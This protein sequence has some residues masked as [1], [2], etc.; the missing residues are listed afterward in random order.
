[1]EKEHSMNDFVQKCGGRTHGESLKMP[2]VFI[3]SEYMGDF[4]QLQKQFLMPPRAETLEQIKCGFLDDQP[5]KVEGAFSH[6]VF[7]R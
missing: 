5:L 4:P 3:E 2:G 7:G 1:M 6:I